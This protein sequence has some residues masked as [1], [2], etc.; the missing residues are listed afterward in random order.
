[1][2]ADPAPLSAAANGRMMAPTLLQCADVLIF[3]SYVNNCV[4][5]LQIPTDRC[6]RLQGSQSILEPRRV[7]MYTPCMFRTKKRLTRK[8]RHHRPLA[9]RCGHTC[10]IHQM[11]VACHS[12][13]QKWPHDT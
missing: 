11:G 5:N 12:C 7:P 6:W 1:M 4:A 8:S 10:P 3:G 9:G 2:L 13:G